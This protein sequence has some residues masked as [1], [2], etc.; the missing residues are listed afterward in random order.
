MRPTLSVLVPLLALAPPAFAQGA[1]TAQRFNYPPTLCANCITWNTPHQPQRIFGNT[2]YVGTQGLSAIL[3]TSRRG[4]VLIDGALPVSAPQIIANIR[5][6]G[7]L[8]EDVK[9]IVNS[10]AHFDHAGG[11]SAL[12]RASGA[13]VAV[14]PKSASVIR[15]GK[16]EPS[17][18]QFVGGLAFPATANVRTIRDGEVIHVGDEPRIAL[19]AHFTPGHTPGGTS[20]SWQSCDGDTCLHVVYADS[21]SAISSDGFLFT[22]KATYPDALTDF[23]R[24]LSTIE[25][26]KCDVLLTPHPDGSRLFERLAAHGGTAALAEPDG[27]AQF[28]TRAREG[29][30]KRIAAER[31]P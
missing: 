17:D 18:P 13:S 26:L 3:I 23:E 15:S 31:K 4:H 10:H 5:A 29:L 25:R 27:C 12:Q 24:G 11:I 14:S 28:V 21:Q 1:D 19:T 30:A 8:V 16:P 9:V 20:W 22:N 2:W 6:L 7:F